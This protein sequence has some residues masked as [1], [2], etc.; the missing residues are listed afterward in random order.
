MRGRQVVGNLPRPV[1]RSIVDDQ[2]AEALVRQ[3]ALRQ[4]RQVVPF[5]VRRD[6]DH[7]IH[8][9][10]CARANTTLAA[11][12]SVGSS[13][14]IRKRSC[15][16]KMSPVRTTDAASSTSGVAA[17]SRRSSLGSPSTANGK[18]RQYGITVASRYFVECSV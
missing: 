6:D 4:H 11:T 9:R 18:R 13:T 2:E 14:G 10:I 3:D 16:K 7:Y 8:E 1:W 15:G 17:L 12:M 5:V